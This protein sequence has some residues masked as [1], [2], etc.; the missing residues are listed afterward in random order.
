MGLETGGPPFDVRVQLGQIAA[1]ERQPHDIAQEGGRL[2]RGEAEV[3][4]A[5][6]QELAAG[7]QPSQG[8]LRIHPHGAIYSSVASVMRVAPICVRI[9]LVTPRNTSIVVVPPRM[10]YVIVSNL[11]WFIMLS[12]SAHFGLAFFLES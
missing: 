2:L 6:L 10:I 1:I 12:W 8:R 7:A 11:A 9:L 3:L 4:P 5:Q